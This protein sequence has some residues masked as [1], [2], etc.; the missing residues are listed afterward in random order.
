VSVGGSLDRRPGRPRDARADVA[1]VEATLA[2]IS[3]RGFGGA[4]IEGIAARAGVGKATIYRRWRSKEELLRFV[5]GQVSDVCAVPDTGN[6]RDDLRAIFEPMGAVLCSSAVGSLVPELIAE[7]AR[8]PDMRSLMR[9]FAE[10][11]RDPALEVIRGA[12]ERRE[13]PSSVDADTVVD[14]ICGAI[15]Y[16]CVVLG[17]PVSHQD[18]D[19]MIDQAL[20]SR[21]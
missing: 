11:R 14:L 18:I 7:A 8:N 17:D 15:V 20:G 5:A 1:I 4:T 10:E 6:V 21:E 9:S 3:E 16:R 2:E 13:L 12:I 19:R